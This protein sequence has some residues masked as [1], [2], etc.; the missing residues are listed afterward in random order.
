M[1]GPGKYNPLLTGKSKKQIAQIYGAAG[2][3]PENRLVVSPVVSH[4]RKRS[5]DMAVKKQTRTMWINETSGLVIKNKLSHRSK[6]HSYGIISRLFFSGAIRYQAGTPGKLFR[7]CEETI[8]CETLKD[9]TVF[10]VFFSYDG[11]IGTN[12]EDG[13]AGFNISL[14]M[15]YGDELKI[16]SKMDRIGRLGAKN[17]K[18]LLYMADNLVEAKGTRVVFVIHYEV[19]LNAGATPMS[20]SEVHFETP[21]NNFFKIIT[22]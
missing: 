4:A 8:E 16:L 17:H 11:M 22:K 15:A 1:E 21:A 5:F 20:V 14:T 7:I 3:L 12:S 6:V 10:D 19:S 18:D 13:S 9:E 2:R